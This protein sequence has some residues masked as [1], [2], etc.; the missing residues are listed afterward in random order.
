MEW[1]SFL[2][3]L[4]ISFVLSLIFS[5]LAQKIAFRFKI[6]DYPGPRKI[7]SKPIPR[8]GGLAFVVAFLL[9]AGIVFLFFKPEISSTRLIGTVL[10]TLV[11]IISGLWDDIKGLTPI[12]KLFW[13]TVAAILVVAGGV[14]ISFLRNPLGGPFPFFNLALKSFNFEILGHH[15]SLVL[16][17]DLIL[18]LWIVAM[19]NILNFLDGLNGLA[20]GVSTIAALTLFGLALRPEVSQVF[21]AMLALV[22]AGS[23]MGFLPFNFPKAKM[24]MG[25]VGSQFLGF[26]LAVMAVISGGK[27]ATLF[28][29]LG[30]PILDFVWVILRRI[31]A[32][33]SPFLADKKHLHHRLL[34]VGLSPVKAVIFIWC[35][36]AVSDCWLFLVQLG[37][38]F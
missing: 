7:H 17:A 11:V 12:K 31:L 26:V 14:E 1:Y 10:G 23:V 16:P 5:F 28:L 27:T 38:N 3:V 20:A 34:A 24:F 29:V 36:T 37:I 32:K 8:I 15:L 22:L 35:W 4:A 25:D 6:L 30:L 33:K 9:I 21:L 18:V 19:I 13:Q 2:V